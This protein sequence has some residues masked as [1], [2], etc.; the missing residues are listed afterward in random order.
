[1]LSPLRRRR[2]HWPLPLSLLFAVAMF[3]AACAAPASPAPAPT[4]TD[5]PP[6]APTLAPTPL[7]TP[8]LLPSPTPSPTA[9]ATPL[10]TPTLTPTPA[11]T[12]TP[13]PTPTFTPAP[14]PTATPLP[15]G[16]LVRIG[17]AVYVVDLATTGA[18]IQQGLSGRPALGADRAMLF[19]YAADGQRAFWMPYMN[20]PL[21]MVWIRSDCTV[22]GVTADVPNPPPDAPLDTLPTYPSH[23]PVR[24]VL[25]INAGQAAQRNIRPG[26]TVRFDGDIA[27][28]WGC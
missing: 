24:F 23:E 22:A 21:D 9:T 10:P 12:A 2:W 5:L 6:T 28:R 14:T 27:G 18:Q 20:F 7:P 1:M 16:P 25:E 15:P 11:P 26:A 13:R 19:V 17:D 3:A 8:T 4:A